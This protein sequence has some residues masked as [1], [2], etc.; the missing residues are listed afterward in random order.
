MTYQEFL[1]RYSFDREKDRLGNGSF[2]T[3][4]KAYDMVLDCWVALKISPVTG[5][6]TR[7][8]REAELVCGL[9][10]HPNIARY[11]ACYTFE[12]PTG[13][14]DV[15]V[16]SY[17]PGGSLADLIDT[18]E[19]SP[20]VMADILAQILEGLKFLHS[21]NVVHRDLKPANI[22][23]A[24]RPDGRI[25]P[26]ITD[27][28]ISRQSDPDE[29]VVE[30]TVTA[31]ATVSYA[32]PEQLSGSG[33]TSASD[34]WSFGVIAYLVASG[35][36]PFNSGEHAPKSLMGRAEIIRQVTS[37]K[38]P[39]KTAALPYPWQTIVRSCLVADPRGRT[40]SEDELIALLR[41]VRDSVSVL[42]RPSD[43]ETR[44]LDAEYVPPVR[45]SGPKGRNYVPKPDLDVPNVKQKSSAELKIVIVILILAL[46]VLTLFLVGTWNRK[47]AVTRTSTERSPVRDRVERYEPERYTPVVADTLAEPAPSP[48]SE[49]ETAETSP[50]QDITQTHDSLSATPP[51]VAMPET[52]PD[53]VDYFD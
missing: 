24:K 42:P 19:T 40:I 1:S 32:S 16:L 49:E 43:A 48:D 28:G 31:A 51:A 9:P 14:I 38:M 25:V 6:G 35:E 20:E 5:E 41:Q 30:E 23:I 12:E 8:L 26:K 3:V 13:A 22:L 10:P 17:Y 44:S 21:R 52:E 46:G 34:T 27:F 11:E 39:E 47:N 33:M 53:S 15:A 36:M 50:E 45:P 2:G 4:Y 29:T 37:G 18:Q 7:L